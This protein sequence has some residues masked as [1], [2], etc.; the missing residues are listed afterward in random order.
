MNIEKVKIPRE[1]AE[2]IKY[3][4]TLDFDEDLR[5]PGSDLRNVYHIVRALVFGQSYDKSTRIIANWIEK[6]RDRENILL[7]ALVNGY[8]IEITP[9]EEAIQ[10]LIKN[11]MLAPGHSAHDVVL[12]IKRILDGDEE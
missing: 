4:R 8:E 10:H 2:A 7:N 9:E 3:V 11:K 1:I 12:L 6:N 5:D